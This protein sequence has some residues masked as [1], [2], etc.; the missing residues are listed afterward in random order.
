[1]EIPKARKGL[2]EIL[3]QHNSGDRSDQCSY[4]KDC[5]HGNS[6]TETFSW[7]VKERAEYSFKILQ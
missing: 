7:R 5:Y 4:L 6:I 3:R 1:M 2:F